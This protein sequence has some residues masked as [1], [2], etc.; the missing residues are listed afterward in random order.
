MMIKNKQNNANDK[1]KVNKMCK[2]SDNLHRKNIQISVTTFKVIT[3]QQQDKFK[4]KAG[5]RIVKLNVSDKKQ[6]KNM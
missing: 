2:V 1:R 6:S 4:M 3:H 5:N